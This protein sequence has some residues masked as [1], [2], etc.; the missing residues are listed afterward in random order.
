MTIAIAALMTVAAGTFA[1]VSLVHFGVVITL[2]P[3]ALD[4]PFA[5]AAV[6]ESV[7]A[8]VLGAGTLNVIARPARSWTSALATTLFALVGTL[9]GLSVT[10]GSSRPADITYHLGVLC[11]LAVIV[12]LLLLPLGRRS[13]GRR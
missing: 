10:L 13:L 2:G 6:P 9:Y 7:I 1:L 11:L 5:G 8:I 4:D 12:A 3:L